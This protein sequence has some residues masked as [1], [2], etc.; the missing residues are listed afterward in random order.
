MR[1]KKK[2]KKQKK[3]RGYKINVVGLMIK[4]NLDKRESRWFDDKRYWSSNLKLLEFC[5]SERLIRNKM[6]VKQTTL[7]VKKAQFDTN[8]PTLIVLF[9]DRKDELIKYVLE[10]AR[11]RRRIQQ[12]EMNDF[13]T[14]IKWKKYPYLLKFVH[15]NV[16]EE[17]EDVRLK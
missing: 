10:R 4:I 7:S 3:T 2:T 6:N 12:T 17:D 9:E 5:P 13:V 14:D 15:V 1:F 11:F 16:D 8:V